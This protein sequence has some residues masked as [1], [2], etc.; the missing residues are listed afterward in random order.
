[1]K[2]EDD[3]VP[4]S[5]AQI[6]RTRAR[7]WALQVHYQWDV[8]NGDNSLLE[9][10]DKVLATRRVA[11]ARIPYM[12]RIA[13]GLDRYGD[14]VDDGLNSV[15]QNW[16]LDRLSVIDRAIL[17]IAALEMLYFKDIPPKV[18]IYEGIRIAE[19]YGGTESPAFVNGVLDAL[20]TGIGQIS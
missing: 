14:Q 19:L 9:I 10:L 4:A 3:S 16:R 8:S 5:S 17:R 1:M 18:S 15:L 6:D 20:M 2:K 11:T 13:S 12:K 7:A